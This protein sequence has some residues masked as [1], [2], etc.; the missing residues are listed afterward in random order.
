MNQLTKNT[1][2]KFIVPDNYHKIL[3]SSKRWIIEWE[4]TL[5]HNR[6][7]NELPKILFLLN[8]DEVFNESKYYTDQIQNDLYHSSFKT[9]WFYNPLNS[10]IYSFNSNFT[11]LRATIDLMN[12][13]E[14]E[15]NK[16]Q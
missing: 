5:L 10:Y 1:E 11:L 4:N 13:L 3:R 9:P 16:F 12:E 14:L 6:V 15:F 2:Y 8:P 7:V